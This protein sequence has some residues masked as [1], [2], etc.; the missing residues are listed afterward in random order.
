MQIKEG[1]EIRN[2][3]GE[4]VLIMQGRYGVDMTKVVSFNATAEWL[5]NSLYGQ[6]F[7]LEDISRLLTE[8]FQVDAETAEADAKKWIEQLMQCKAIE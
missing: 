1:L 7:S 2:I 5:W 8:R 6:T 3:A 4:K